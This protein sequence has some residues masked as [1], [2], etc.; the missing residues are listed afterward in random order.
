MATSLVF[1]LLGFSEVLVCF[2]RETSFD[3]PIG[4]GLVSPCCGLFC[5]VCSTT[6]HCSGVDDASTIQETA[7]ID[8]EYKPN[9]NN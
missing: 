5:S 8:L 4:V 6:G 3:G 9:F 7:E 2:G 1:V